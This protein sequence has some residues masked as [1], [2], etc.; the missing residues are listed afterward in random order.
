MNF[1]RGIPIIRCGDIHIYMHKRQREAVLGAS[2]PR[3]GGLPRQKPVRSPS[4]PR[5][6][7][8]PGQKPVRSLSVP[9]KGGLPGRKPVRSPSVPRKG[10]L[11]GQKPVLSLSV[12]RKGGL[13]GRKGYPRRQ[14]EPLGGA[15]CSLREITLSPSSAAGAP[16]Q[17]GN[18][19]HKCRTYPRQA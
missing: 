6:G 2:V 4:V 14:S 18:D 15:R 10:G 19:L 7:G 11:P 17:Q 12:P 1:K 16:G 13:P 9:R 8:L 3:K 5:K